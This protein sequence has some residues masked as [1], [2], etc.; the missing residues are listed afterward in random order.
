[1]KPAPIKTSFPAEFIEPFSDNMIYDIIFVLDTSGSL[2][3]VMNGL[4]LRELMIEGLKNA[5]IQLKQSSR[6]ADIRITLVFMHPDLVHKSLHWDFVCVDDVDV[7]QLARLACD[8]SDTPFYSTQHF[9]LDAAIQRKAFLT[10]EEIAVSTTVVTLTDGLPSD[11]AK[12]IKSLDALRRISAEISGSGSIKLVGIGVD[13]E[14]TTPVLKEA[15]PVPQQGIMRRL[16][17]SASAAAVQAVMPDN[18]YTKVFKDLGYAPEN[19]R[20]ANSANLAQVI[21][22]ATQTA[23]S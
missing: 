19:I 23:T 14:E 4:T 15:V 20:N 10:G 16:F 6:S 9:T 11:S 21:V 3:K 18:P 2:D 7:D 17:S 22:G 1:M 12:E 5:M 8:G 13:G